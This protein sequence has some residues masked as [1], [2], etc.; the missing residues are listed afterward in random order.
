MRVNKVVVSVVVLVLLVVIYVVGSIEKNKQLAEENNHL[1]KTTDTLKKEKKEMEKMILRLESLPTRE[2]QVTIEEKPKKNKEESIVS[3]NPSV[4][5]INQAFVS[6]SFNF[7]SSS[8]RTSNM[9]PYMTEEL[10]SQYDENRETEKTSEFEQINVSGKLK[11]YKLYTQKIE[12]GKLNVLNDVSVTY[13]SGSE[14]TEHRMMFSVQYDEKT[15]KVEGI[16][17]I[18]VISTDD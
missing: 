16:Q 15:L 1:I 7:K 9:K 18:P 6:A 12:N 11:E 8:D 3:A 14:K 5:K 17:F 4:E 13:D 10:Q 2:E